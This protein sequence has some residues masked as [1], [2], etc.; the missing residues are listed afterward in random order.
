MQTDNLNEMIHSDLEKYMGSIEIND[1]SPKD[2]T[3]HVDSDPETQIVSRV[4]TPEIPAD[5]YEPASEEALIEYATNIHN[6]VQVYSISGYWE[7]GRSI[8]AFYKGKY[9][10]HELE[11]IARATG[12]GRD[13]LN[14]MIKFAKEF[15]RDHVQVL[16]SGIYPMSWFYIAQ[17]LSVPPDKIIQVYQESEDQKQ[18]HNNIMKFK[19]RR[20]SKGQSVSGKSSVPAPPGRVM[21]QQLTHPIETAESVPKDDKKAEETIRTL[22]ERNKQLRKELDDAMR[23]LNEL[24]ILFHDADKDIAH[25]SDL[26]DRLR[27]ALSQVYEMVEN[28]CN[29]EDILAEVEWG[30]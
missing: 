23:D 18:F 26:I 29:H 10:T 25:K 17:N 28:G 19:T 8:N 14:K 2:T 22:L 3:D 12:I 24:K 13:T 30:L 6:R 9:G 16:L 7:I 15:S 1:P 27:D 20:E 5:S 4:N 11:R 21:S